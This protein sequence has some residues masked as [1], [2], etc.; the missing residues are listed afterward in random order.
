MRATWLIA[1]TIL[2]VVWVPVLILPVD[3]WVYALPAALT[4]GVVVGL[5]LYEKRAGAG[6]A[7]SRKRALETALSERL[8]AL[9][10]SQQTAIGTMREDLR[11][12]VAKLAGAAPGQS[13]RGAVD[14]LPWYLVIGAPQS[15]KSALLAATGE[16]FG[17]VTPAS[18]AQGSRGVRFWLAQHAA[19]LDTSG[20]YMSGEA[21]YAEWLAFLSELEGTRPGQPLHG[22]VVTLPADTAMQSRPDDV[23]AMGKRARERVDEVLGYLGIDVPVYLVV[24]RCDVLPGFMEFF[25]DLRGSERGQVLGFTLPARDREP[26]A[27]RVG[28]LFD[29]LAAGLERRMYRRVLPR[30]HVE[31]RSASY[32]FPQWFAGLKAG[33]LAYAQRLFASS[34]YMDRITARGVYF[35]TAADVMT[36]VAS[37]APYASAPA[38][39]R[40][41]F[42][43]D[44][45]R[46]VMLP[47]RELAR[48]SASELQRRMLRR[49]A[50]AAPL[51]GVSLALPVLGYHAYAENLSMLDDFRKAMNDCVAVQP[52]VPL[53]RLDVLRAR[54][55]R[56]R[57]LEADGPPLHMRMGMYVGDEVQRRTATVYAALVYREV[58]AGA[59][60]RTTRS[61]G[62]FAA[63]YI[64]VQAPPTNDERIAYNDTLRLYLMLTTPR[65][66]GDPQLSDPSQREWFKH[67]LAQ[68]WNL[69]HPATDPLV[70]AAREA[71][72]D[73]DALVLAAD[74][75]LG[76]HR[77]LQLVTRV[78]TVLAR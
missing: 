77:D 39:E 54:V 22:V 8:K 48:P 20:E 13:A 33:V 11:E 19:F 31:V 17:F 70:V 75:R 64:G 7:G 35:T 12:A 50:I 15:G 27:A 38:G 44:L 25:S 62:A 41:M 23:D 66:P 46:A 36:V 6:S 34:V 53:P 5:V 72:V 71:V 26:A 61:L 29:E 57:A 67:R 43:R 60:E 56:I 74:Q 2:A 47:D 16:Q 73:L 49:L 42:V 10:P 21:A 9:G 51:L 40:G 30:A 52:P 3:G 63:R 32:M 1:A 76:D 24:T 14:A 28:R 78:K 65:A 18:G 4:I 59:N 68:E 69:T 55:D 45:V 58:G 37:D